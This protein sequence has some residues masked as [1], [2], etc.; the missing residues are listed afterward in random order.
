MAMTDP[1]DYEARFADEEA[2][3]NRLLAKARPVRDEA[4]ELADIH[5][6]IAAERAASGRGV[7]DEALAQAVFDKWR[8]I[9]KYIFARP[10]RVAASAARSQQWREAAGRLAAIDDAEFA[11]WL[12]LQ[13]EV[14]ANRE[15]GLPDYR[16]R[17]DGPV[18][19]ILLEYVG[20]RK[21]TALAVLHWTKADGEG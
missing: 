14:A 9:H 12:A 8:L 11:D 17:R 6:A 15:Q 1:E 4:A 19:L 2:E 20:N 18:F 10:F 3:L 5:A 13:A 21:R 16:I 7:D